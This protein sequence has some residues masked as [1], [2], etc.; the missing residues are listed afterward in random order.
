MKSKIFSLAVASLFAFTALNAQEKAGH[1]EV[2]AKDGF[3]SHWFIELGNAATVNY[4]GDN[5]KADFGDRVSYVNPTLAVGRWHLPYFATRV[6][7]MAGEMIDYTR[8]SKLPSQITK[9]THEYATAQL[10]FMFDVSNFFAPYKANRVFLFIPFVGVGTTYLHSC[11]YKALNDK[12]DAKTFSPSAHL[13][14]QLKFHFAKRFDLNLEAQAIAQDLRI[15]SYA[16]NWTAPNEPVSFRGGVMA[17]A[18]ASLGINLGKVE[19]TPVVPQD[20]ELLKSLNDK[21][22]T[23]R[24][25]NVELAKRPEFC[26]ELKPAEVVK[27]IAIGNVVYFR[28]N[29]AHVDANQRIN[30]HNLAQYAKNNTEVIT[31]VGYAD[32]KTGTLE[33][34][35]KLSQRRAEAVKAILVKKYGIA[36]ERIQTSWEGD[37]VQP[38]DVN[39]W[40][41]VVIMNAR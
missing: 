1:K 13:G 36:A 32:R 33:Y 4:G 21:L 24:A 40:N 30:I 34:N 39:K 28:L 15:K 10:D 3:G 22:N 7:V 37:K 41:R 38:Y 26:P 35:Y 18:G 12:H 5:S 16:T 31:L 27:S 23:L 2:F 14:L 9:G 29:S 11:E 17:M 19:F 20:E 8:Y 6:Q 25:E